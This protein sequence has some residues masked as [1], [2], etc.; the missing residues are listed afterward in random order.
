VGVSQHITG[1]GSSSD[2]GLQGGRRQLNVSL[3][4]V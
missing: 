1:D 2:S 3:V 4:L